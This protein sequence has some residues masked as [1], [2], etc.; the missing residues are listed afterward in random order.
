MNYKLYSFSKAVLVIAFVSFI[1]AASPFKAM[2]MQDVDLTTLNKILSRM[3]AKNAEEEQELND[4]IIKLGPGALYAI[5]ARLVPMGAGDDAGAR[6]ALSSM[7]HHVNRPG[8]GPERKMFAEVMLRGLS[9]ASNNEVKSF[10][11]RRLQFAGKQEVVQ[12]LGALLADEALCEPATRALIA[13]GSGA[14]ERCLID[15]LAGNCENNQLTLVYA[16]GEMKSKAAAYEIRKCL[17]TD[18]DEL[19][20]AVVYALANIG[21]VTIEALL[22]DSWQSSSNYGK[23]KTLSY[24]V[25]HIK[26]MAEMGMSPEASELCR[27]VLAGAGPADSNFRIAVLAILVEEQGILALADLLKAAGSTQ[28]DMRMA[29]L[30]LANGIPGTNTTIEL[31]NKWKAASPELQAEL[32]YVLQKRDEQ[33]M[34]PE[35]AE[36]MKLWPDEA[37]FVHLFN[38]KDLTGWKGLVADPVQRAKM[39]AAELA[40]AQ[41]TADEVMNASWTVEDGILVF[42]GHGSHLCTVKDYKDF[43]MHVDWK[44]EAGG[45]SG[46]YLR[47]APQVQIWDTAQ[48]PEGSGGLY[49]NQNNPAKPSK[50]ADK[51]VGEWNTFRIRMIGERVTVYLNDVLVVDDV[52]MENYWERNKPIYPTGQIELQSHGSKLQFKH[53]KIKELSAAD[54][55][56]PDVFVLEADFELLF[57]GEDLTGWVG[58]KTGYIAEDGKIVVHPE[59]G[60][61]SGNLYTEKEYTDFNYRFDFKLTENANNGLGIRAP[62]EGDAA[63]VGIELQILDN[64]GEMYQELKEWQY[65]GSAYGIAAAKRGYLKT[66]GSWNTEEVIVKGKHIQVMINDVMILDVDL[67]EATKNG[68][69]DGRDHPGLS[70]TKGHIGFLGHGSHV[71]FKNIR[72]KELK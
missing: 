58:D 4:S 57:N 41:V 49:N 68:T 3:P 8:L 10:L 47:G 42:D 48:W 38:G 43:E 72:I 2:A 52:L 56:D 67:D 50:V 70:R 36:A 16:L 19:R 62:L 64:T 28:K 71:E 15:A 32:Q 12:P 39:S 11:I 23:A 24:Y 40:A 34:I 14:A 61:G 44:I 53:I 18:N 17:A 20:L 33:F 7:T 55:V 31:F 6:Y 27:K 51:A 22:R 1:T 69:I 65:H 26:R 37:G 66:V 21:P 25:T 46:I 60:G 45:D 59:L 13:I 29:A 9:A 30:E 35:L 54:T 63:Y 5:C